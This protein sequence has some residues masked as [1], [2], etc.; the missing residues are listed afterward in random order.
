MEKITGLS[1][2]DTALYRLAIDKNI[3]D[4][5]F[6][7]CAKALKEIGKLEEDI[8][9]LKYNLRKKNFFSFFSKIKIKRKIKENEAFIQRIEKKFEI[10]EKYYRRS[11]NTE[12]LIEKFKNE[13]I[14][15]PYLR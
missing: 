14:I 10:L 8:E 3:N 2:Q 6:E 9:R 1:I 5:T 13:V 4:K 15:P 12:A 7:V 11:F